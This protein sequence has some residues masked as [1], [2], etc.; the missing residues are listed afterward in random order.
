M[1]SAL[2]AALA[3]ERRLAGVGGCLRLP[4]ATRLR[5]L[6]PPAVLRCGH[7]LEGLGSAVERI[8]LVDGRQPFLDPRRVCRREFETDEPP[9]E[10]LGDGER[11]AAAAEWIQHRVA[12]VARRPN[13]PAEQLLGHLAAVPAGTFLECAADAGEVPRVG[14]GAKALGQVLW[15]E[16]P[17][18]VR[19]P[20]GR[21]GP[22]VAVDEFAGA[23]HPD[24]VGVEREVCGIL[25]EVKDVGMRAAE[26]L[27]AVDAEGVIPDH[28]AAAGEPEIAGCDH[29]EFGRI[30]VAD[31]QP[32]R[33]VRREHAAHLS[34]PPLRPLEIV[35]GREP[36]VVGVVVVSNVEGRVGECQL[37]ARGGHPREE[38]ET[39]APVDPIKGERACR[40]DGRRFTHSIASHG[41]SL[42]GTRTTFHGGDV[43]LGREARSASDGY[44]GGGCVGGAEWSGVAGVFPALALGAS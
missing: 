5:F 27:P 22:L 38:I 41:K 16:D 31:R 13:D 35:V 23:R 33:P 28:P 12:F 9:A 40:V 4:A 44:A 30:F 11:G 34:H 43:S 37:H 39:V 1:R 18:V 17:G 32:E 24:R 26:L 14:V 36:I 29:L 10:F 20:A 7:A 19:E 6:K 8:A 25:H 3:E 2:L 21:A 15:A 42:R